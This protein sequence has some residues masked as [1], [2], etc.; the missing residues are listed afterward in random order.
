MPLGHGHLMQGNVL[1]TI[2]KAL[3]ITLKS[4]VC[5]V[6]GGRIDEK[7]THNFGQLLNET[8]FEL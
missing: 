7:A 5:K 3:F 4:L 1:L 8:G 6:A 2:K